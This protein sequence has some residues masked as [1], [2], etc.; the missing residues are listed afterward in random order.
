MF[1]HCLWV[2][3]QS[4]GKGLSK[5]LLESCEDDAR[6]TRMSGVAMMTS[7][8]NWL[9]GKKLLEKNGYESVATAPPSFNLMVKKFK[10]GSLPTFTNN[11][12]SNAKM[13]GDGL[14]IF[15]TSQCPYR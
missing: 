4:K 14:T 7:E 6:N 5:R 15:T 12:E 11:W 1:I 10:N 8:G 13:C 3:G 9:M 2:V